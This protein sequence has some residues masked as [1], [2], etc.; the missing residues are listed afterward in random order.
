[1]DR[2]LNSAVSDARDAM[3]N[4]P[5]DTLGAY[6]QQIPASQRVGALMAPF[7]LRLMPMY[8]LA[9]LKSVSV[10]STHNFVQ[11]YYS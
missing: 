7:S 6:A 5:V 2:S 1:M 3:I 10:A 11:I 9:L 8:M 4:A